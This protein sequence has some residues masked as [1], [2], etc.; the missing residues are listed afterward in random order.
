MITREFFNIVYKW[1]TFLN[2]NDPLKKATDSLI[3]SIC[4]IKPEIF[5]FL[6][7]KM[8][9]LKSNSNAFDNCVSDDR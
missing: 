6:L 2:N 8:K 9:I 5:T 4:F 1:T 3:C 7:R